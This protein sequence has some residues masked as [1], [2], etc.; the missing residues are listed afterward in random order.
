M[1]AKSTMFTVRN[2][3]SARLPRLWLVSDVLKVE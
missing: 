2:A 3:R 1:W